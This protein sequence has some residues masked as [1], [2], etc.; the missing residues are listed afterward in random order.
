MSSARQLIERA[1]RDRNEPK[2]VPMWVT[3]LEFAT[4]WAVVNEAIPQ[5]S[6]AQAEKIVREMAAKAT[7]GRD[8]FIM[9][10]AK[11]YCKDH[12]YEIPSHW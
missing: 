6:W 8:A 3:P 9:I 2:T 4:R 1:G 10:L 12:N 7:E 5:M 11:Q